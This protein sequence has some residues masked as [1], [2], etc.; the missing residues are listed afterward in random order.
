MRALL[1]CLLLTALLP[2]AVTIDG[3]FSVR[4]IVGSPFICIISASGSGSLQYGASGL[5]AGLTIN[6]ATGVIS[7]TPTIATT[8]TVTISATGGSGSADM[9]MDLTVEAVSLIGFPTNAASITTTVGSACSFQ[10]IASTTTTEFFSS[11][12]PSG[13]SIAS[14]G[15]IS[16]APFAT[17]RYSVEL[18]TDSGITATT[19]AITVLPA[20]AGAPSIQLSVQPLAAAG[21]PFGCWIDAPGADTFGCSNLPAWLQLNGSSGSLIGT[22]ASTDTTVNLQLTASTGAA[23]SSTVMA[24]PVTVPT[25]AGQLPIAPPMV[26][27][28]V[29]SS[30][31]WKVRTGAPTTLSADNLPGGLSIDAASGLLV[32]IPT[33][34]G[35]YNVVITSTPDAPAVAVS[36]TTGMRIRDTTFGA[37]VIGELLP[38]LLTVGAPTAYAIPISGFDPA[39]RFTLSGDTAFTIDASGMIR[40][41]PTTAGVPALRITAINDAGSSVTTLMLQIAARN[42]AGPLPTS[43]SVFRTT[44][45]SAFAASLLADAPVTSWLAS[46]LPSGISLAPF[47][48]YLTGATTLDGICNISISAT[49]TD[50]G[51]PTHIVLQADVPGTGAPVIAS[52]GPWHLGTGQPA[53]IALKAD[54]DA[55]WSATGLPAGLSLTSTGSITGKATTA[56]TAN[57]VVTA[58]AGSAKAVTTALFVVETTPT[59]APV[60][61]DPGLLTAII[62]TP[63]HATLVAS[64]SPF[65][66]TISNA[67]SWLVLDGPTGILSGI[68]I[69][70]E[71]LVM[72]VTARNAMGTART[73]VVIRS[74]TSFPSDGGGGSS[75]SGVSGVSG[76]GCGA[77][78]AGLL[79]ASLL[80][81]CLRR[82]RCC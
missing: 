68:P 5:P 3:P 16:G 36:T 39:K 4:G 52:A 79:V 74:G 1:L 81:M 10:V 34:S 50:G 66:Y 11:N 19:M 61:S 15:L 14:D 82:S 76:G 56:G 42:A 30:I 53:R 23:S 62:D 44:S 31:G 37:P 47:T 2:A 78:A 51:N 64:E 27:G 57:V 75:S 17:G 60:F 49:D 29:D 32:G 46:D 6:Q 22:P 43:P 70:T 20:P 58:K 45:G 24:V 8:S 80:A 25:S 9:T 21:A 73:T 40:G 59:G 72:A 77:G 35:T 26:D 18:S 28:T 67:P 54:I 48:G 55:A 69:D 13:L 12:L 63:F 38:P 7:G 71:T 65:E 41:T 33:A